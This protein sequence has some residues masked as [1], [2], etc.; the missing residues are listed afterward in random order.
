MIRITLDD[1]T[2]DELTDYP[3][4]VPGDVERG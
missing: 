2:R 1:A 4:R 3:I